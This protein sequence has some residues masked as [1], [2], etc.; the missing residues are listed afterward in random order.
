M[1]LPI[2]GLA[3]CVSAFLQLL[4]IPRPIV[5][6]LGLI[7]VLGST[8]RTMGTLGVWRDN[9]TRF[10]HSLIQNPSNWVAHNNVGVSAWQIGDFKKAYSHFESAYRLK[11]TDLPIIKNYARSLLLN[12]EREKC[13]SIAFNGL[14]LYPKCDELRETISIAERMR[15]VLTQGEP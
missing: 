15:N 1:Y 3:I 6:I 5:L 14:N 4:N 12:N 9:T 11:P 8:A 13:L 10:E 7:I 2:V